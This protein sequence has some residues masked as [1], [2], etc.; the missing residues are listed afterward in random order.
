MRALA[1]FLARAGCAVALAGTLLA[2]LRAGP[3]HAAPPIDVSG[4]ALAPWLIGFAT[5]AAL[6]ARPSPPPR[7]ARPLLAGVALLL[8]ALVAFVAWRGPVG[9]PAAAA[10]EPPW[11]LLPG[12]IDVTPTDLAEARGEV[13][14]DGPLQ[15]PRTGRYRLWAIGRG[16]VTL[17]LDG[18]QVLAA[19][20]EELAAAAEIAIGRGEHRLVLRYEK[21]GRPE[22]R[23]ARIRGHRL[24]LGWVRPRADGSPGSVSEAIAPRYLGEPRP[25]G[26]WWGIDALCV[27]LAVLA[28]ALAFLG[29]WERPAE[30]PSQR[31]ATRR[32]W[33]LSLA[34]YAAVL[35]VMSWPLVADLGG[36]GIVDRADGR[37]SVWIMA[38]GAHS[39]WAGP[40]QW[41]EAPIF[42]PAAQAL[43]FSENMLLPAL[44]AAPFSLAGGPVLGYNL[45][46]LAGA[47]LSGLGVQLLVRRACGDGLAAFVAGV[48]YAA[49]AHRWARIV[50][51]HEQFTVLLPFA[52]LALDRYW[53]QRTR[54]AALLLGLTLALQALA[55][56]YLGV[57]LATIVGLLLLVGGLRLGVAD[58]RR[59]A[60]GLALAA[61]LVAPLLSPYLKMRER[62]GAEWS[63]EAIEPHSLTPA[64]YLA[65]G[66]RL[67]ARL[68]E[69]SMDPDLRRR[70]LFPGVVPFALGIA[71]LAAAPRR[72]RTAAL[73]GSLAAFLLSLGPMTPFYRA[74]YDG[75]FVF[76]G[77]RGVFRFAAVPVLM[78]CALSAFALAGRRRLALLALAFGLLEA[79]SAPL[80]LGAYGG[81]SPTARWLAG[82]PGAVAYLPMGEGEDAQAML[83]EIPY[84][85]PLINGYSSFTPPHYRWLP[86]LLETPLSEDALRLL[87]AFDVRHVVARERLAL[88]LAERVGD[89]WIHEVPV[90]ERAR[91]AACP[92]TPVAAVWDEEG[93]RFDLG[94]VRGISR[95]TFELGERVPEREPV[96]GVSSDGASFRPVSARFDAGGAVVALAESPRRA[97]A[98]IRLATS[99]SARFVR[100]AF[101]PAR[102]GGLVAVD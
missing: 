56:I 25:A 95:V 68:T 86:D 50:H 72:Y 23:A 37:L 44:V 48:L 38:W 61:V 83:D 43:A 87:R 42:H 93:A 41:F 45:A 85:R 78:L 39:L 46:F 9:L 19:E 84:F 18:K 35:A 8:V 34:G 88:P 21:T 63:L 28:G 102:R 89:D 40:S 100:L 80:R 13:V 5:V 15:A 94:A 92:R 62:Y 65:S 16:K 55:S 12:P 1:S 76:R 98:E 64:S 52:L 90:G 74:L 79:W 7:A 33:A 36:R 22:M 75:V 26:L 4:L 10:G 27:L 24:T 2:L 91:P 47:L 99:E 66:T 32:E 96:V 59:L 20:G 69:R 57:I 67:Y 31:V 49:G 3:V 101:G 97:C 60:A 11:R 6:T 17:E 14:W 29:R 58:L 77:L 82:K 30:V 70:P 71:G 81:P 54:R 53:E 73:L 51:M